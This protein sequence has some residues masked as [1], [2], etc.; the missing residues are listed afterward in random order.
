MVIPR[1]KVTSNIS[2]AGGEMG[3]NEALGRAASTL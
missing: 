2:D 3:G 1:E